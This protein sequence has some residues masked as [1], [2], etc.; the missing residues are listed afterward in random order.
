MQLTYAEDELEELY[1]S[2]SLSMDN[3]DSEYSDFEEKK[4]VSFALK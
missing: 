2:S 4:P 1:S 3:S